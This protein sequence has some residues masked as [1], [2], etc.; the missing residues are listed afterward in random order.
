[1]VIAAGF[2]VVGELKGEEEDGLR[3]FGGVS[4]FAQDCG[5]GLRW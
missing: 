2:P 4:Y 5:A 3:S 1:M